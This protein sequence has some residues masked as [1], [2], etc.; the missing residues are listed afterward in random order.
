[1]DLK[2]YPVSEKQ[3]KRETLLVRD[4]AERGNWPAVANV[5][6]GGPLYDLQDLTDADHGVPSQGAQW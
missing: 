6:G 5:I 3:Q 4:Y 2:D 1:M